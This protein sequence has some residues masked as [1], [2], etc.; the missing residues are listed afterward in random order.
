M[1]I[2]IYEKRNKKKLLSKEKGISKSKKIKVK[3]KKFSHIKTAS[4]KE[5]NYRCGEKNS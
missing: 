3:E 1:F 4:D 5:A 2:Q